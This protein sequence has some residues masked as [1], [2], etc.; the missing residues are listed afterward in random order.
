MVH[1]TH[2]CEL[3]HLFKIQYVL[4]GPGKSVTCFCIVE[5]FHSDS[6]NL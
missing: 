1:V 5:H 4:E 3:D 2:K 6:E